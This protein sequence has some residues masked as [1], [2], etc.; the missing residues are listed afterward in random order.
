M[1]SVCLLPQHA[2]CTGVE[3]QLGI[4]ALAGD[5]SPAD[6]SL[7][8]I[9]WTIKNKYYT[10]QVHFQPIHI[11]GLESIE[12]DDVPA[13]IYAWKA[14]EVCICSVFLSTIAHNTFQPYKAHLS[15]ISEEISSS[16]SKPEVSLA[17][18]MGSSSSEEEDYFFDLGF[19]YIDGYREALQNT[20]IDFDSKA[21]L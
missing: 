6:N 7:G 12:L 15:L 8:I 19:E 13:I 14:T 10:A 11:E 9:H 2:L 16:S 4:K 18:N 1:P 5:T 20:S 21:I 3:T 17:V